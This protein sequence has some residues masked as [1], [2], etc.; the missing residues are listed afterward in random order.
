[1]LQVIGSG[2]AVGAGVG[3]GVGVVFDPDAPMLMIGKSIPL[4]A[5]I[6]KDTTNVTPKQVSI[7]LV[8]F[9]YIAQI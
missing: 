5:T 6:K 1:V 4:H 8:C 2:V 3:I 7:L 9:L